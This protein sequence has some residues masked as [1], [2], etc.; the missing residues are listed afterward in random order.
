MTS[1]GRILGLIS[2]GV[3][4][5]ACAD[6]VSSKVP[7]IKQ[8]M[9]AILSSFKVG[10]TSEFVL[11]AKDSF[12]TAEARFEGAAAESVL[13]HIDEVAM[14]LGYS[15]RVRMAQSTLTYKIFCNPKENALFISV[16]EMKFKPSQVVV[17]VSVTGWPKDKRMC[18]LDP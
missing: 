17:S 5:T 11:T 14:N 3:F 2:V 7:L 1:I 8:E 10:S 13:S 6:S 15:T 4:L 16:Q 18:R 9:S 12:V